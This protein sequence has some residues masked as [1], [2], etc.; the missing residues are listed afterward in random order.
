MK[1]LPYYKYEFTTALPVT[2]VLER[3][4]GAIGTRKMLGYFSHD[5]PFEGEITGTEIDFLRIS[6]FRNSFKP[7][8][9]AS[10][11]DRGGHARVQVIMKLQPL[12]AGFMAFWFGVPLLIM[13][14]LFLQ[15]FDQSEIPFSTVLAP[16]WLLLFGLLLVGVG[17]WP[18]VFV[19]RKKIR[20]LFEDV[21]YRELDA[22]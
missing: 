17:F 21:G 2:Q 16:G 10:V 11:F 9:R 1:I 4:V 6:F 5:K 12:V 15:H 8:I 22:E 13:L 19:A 14:M 20:A 7:C 18:E 3:F